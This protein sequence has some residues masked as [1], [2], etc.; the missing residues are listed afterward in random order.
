MA[1]VTEGYLIA[2]KPVKYQGKGLHTSHGHSR[3][4]MELLSHMGQ[5]SPHLG[6]EIGDSSQHSPL[7]ASR[8]SGVHKPMGVKP[9]AFKS[10]SNSPLQS[11]HPK[12]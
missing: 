8:S 3:S 11:E 1:K 9:L 4:Y 5:G 7:V 12:A 6:L 10:Q 2:G